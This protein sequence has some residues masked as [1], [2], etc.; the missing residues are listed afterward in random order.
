M[1][2]QEKFDR[3][4]GYIEEFVACG[5]PNIPEALVKETG[6]NVRLL[7]D[8]FQFM[9]DMTMIQYIRK[10]KLVHALT[11]RIEQGLSIEQVV[12]KSG[13]SDAAAFS[14][15]CKNVFGLSPSQIT[16]AVLK[17]HPPLT[18]ARITTG[19]TGEALENDTVITEKRQETICG[20]T[21]E[22][23]AEVKQVLELAALYGLTDEEAEQVYR[24]SRNCKITTAQAAEFYEDFKLQV[25]NGSCYLGRD[26]FEMAELSCKYNLSFS[27]TQSVMEELEHAGYW[28][29]HDLPEY[30]FD[31]Y[32]CKE[33]D[34]HGWDV[35]YICEIAEAMKANG[36]TFSQFDDVIFQADM[37]G[38]DLVDAA[39][40]FQ[41]YEA[42]WDDELDKALTF[43]I[44]EDDPDGFGYRSIWELP[45]K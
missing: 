14:K 12:E 34:R 15:A 30:F 35:E 23:F 20:I 26:L 9:T 24:L 19:R 6:T 28:S 17:Q 13:F 33:N 45:E 22:Q 43:G 41:E 44:P 10:R 27:E 2:L 42:S 18:F 37:N 1:T 29:I 36:L 3:M 25:E 21:P 32:F 4:I 11:I 39:E 8:A 31:I 16:E 5:E 7:A 38:T 40:N